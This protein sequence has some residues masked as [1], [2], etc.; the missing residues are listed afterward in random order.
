MTYV[1]KI[2]EAFGGVRPMARALRLPV[3]TVQSW[4]DRGTIPDARKSDVMFKAR[5]LDL[6]LGWS[7]FLPADITDPPTAPTSPE[8]DVA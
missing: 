7:D 1:E 2:C 3:S 8:K 4:K 6:G 5:Q